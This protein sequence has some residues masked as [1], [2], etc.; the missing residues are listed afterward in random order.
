MAS[1]SSS[2]LHAFEAEQRGEYPFPVVDTVEPPSSPSDSLPSTTHKS[3]RSDG[4][5]SHHR[6]RYDRERDEDF[7]SA[8]ARLLARLASRDDRD[9][10]HVR[11]LLVLTTER[12][13]SETRRADQAEQRVIDTLHRL[14]AAHE[15]TTASRA[16]TARANETLQLY[17]LQLDY[18]Q[19]EI[20]RAQDILNQ[21]ENE[22]AEAA[23]EAARAR[24]TARRLREDNV[25]TKARE[26]G[27][28]EGYQ[29]GLSVGRS[30]MTAEGRVSPRAMNRRL[31]PR[32]TIDDEDEDVD[33][34]PVRARSPARRTSSVFRISP[35]KALMLPGHNSLRMPIHEA[36][37]SPSHPPY[38]MLPD[39]YIPL[40]NDSR[41]IIMPPPHELSR[42]V[43][44][45]TPIPSLPET[46]LPV[47]PSQETLVQAQS[48]RSR[49]FA[50]Y[51][52]APVQDVDENI[53][54]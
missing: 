32:P 5:S 6:R 17:K 24:S 28:R 36:P 29:E 14:R 15:A 41:D 2:V 9:I 43:T 25:I 19:R 54:V 16:E 46:I 31:P 11:T 44:P 18:A 42:P 35:L 40:A 30:M 10:K 34:S 47:A 50:Y 7:T 22:R 49:D 4:T 23:A 52:V 39:N 51:N 13:D 53:G 33:D 8:S 37:P 20:H 45:T 48:V 12:L 21:V 3:H 38:D 26:Q 27:R 1:G